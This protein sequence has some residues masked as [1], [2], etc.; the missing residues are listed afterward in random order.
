MKDTELPKQSW[1]VAAGRGAGRKQSRSPNSP[2]FR[3]YC[4][5]TVVKSMC[6][7]YKNRHKDQGNR[8]E[9]PEI[10]SDTH[11]QLIFVKGGK[12]IKREKTVSSASDTLETG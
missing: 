12:N 1:S 7:W 8:A 5:A 2:D 3:K 11:G 10:N 4:R 9:S 6:Y